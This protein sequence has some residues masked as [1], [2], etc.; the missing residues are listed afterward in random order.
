M[1]KTTE[2]KVAAVLEELNTLKRGAR[3]MYEWNIKQGDE[4]RANVWLWEWSTLNT[5]TEIICRE[6]SV[7]N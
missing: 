3:S 2:T 5:A 6:F 7:E 4:V 1:S